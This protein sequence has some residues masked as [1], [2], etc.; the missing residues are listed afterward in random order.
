MRRLAKWLGIVV[1]IVVLLVGGAALI[2]PMVI[3]ID[4]VK[5]EI[6]A[7]VKSATGRDLTIDGPLSLSILPSPSISASKVSLANVP[8]AAA[9]PLASLGKLELK[10][11]L[12][13]LLSKTIVIDR[14]VLVD[15]VINLEVDKQGNGNWNFS[16]AGG[17]GAAPQQQPASSGASGGGS[18]TGALGLLRL[19]DVR[20]ENGTVNY[21]D[22]RSGVH[23][24]VDKID[25]TVSLPS[26]DAPLKADGSLRYNN[27]AVL[28]TLAA[29]RSSGLLAAEGTPA[30]ATIKSDLVNFGFKGTA[31][32]VGTSNG[33]IDLK[34][35]SLR[36][37]AAWAGS[38]IP[39]QTQTFG[40]FEIVG[41]L[42]LAAS[43]IKFSDAQLTFD[44][45][46]GK[47]EI[48]VSTAGARPK[49]KGTLDLASLDLNPYFPPTGGGAAG[50]TGGGGGGS[51]GG[52]S[53][54]SD[55]QF[56]VSG[57]KL[58]DADF[59]LTASAVKFHK[60]TVDRSAITARL[61]AGHLTVD[62][63]DLAAYRGSGKAT[64][65]LDAS[66]AVPAITLNANLSGVQM[67]PLL[68]DVISLDKLSG[69]GTISA[70]LSSKGPSQ[71]ALITALNGKGSMNVANGQISGMDLLKLLNSATSAVGNALT[72]G[73]DTK[74]SHLTGTFTITN[75]IMH[76]N[77]LVLD[78]P[79]LKAEG[80]GTIDLPQR[81][82]DYKV[83]PKVV[84]FGV[85]I[86]VQGPFDNLSY[87]PDVAG[88]VKG[89]ATG[90]VD[91]LKSL[92]PG[93][94]SSGG[95]SSGSG[96]S[97]GGGFPLPNPFK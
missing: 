38:P 3:P 73:G 80:A 29:D 21:S 95:G 65:V 83:T 58:A 25:M 79:G 43:D 30:T 66:A 10:V 44:A 74:F 12:L 81:R 22:Q 91:T 8:G 70:S 40:T 71:R 76:N 14:F 19:S 37:L 16:P 5:G 24:T 20:L 68:S 18:A 54:W 45:I 88:I 56:D 53:G 48:E 15:P 51:S 61:D 7:Q 63:T 42:A 32:L 62:L 23:K 82:V 94:G 4:T 86:I 26:L 90:A 57:F 64:I 35:P 46:K 17:A 1:G 39:G 52:S 49:I 85:P 60:I 92:V 89:G 87:I 96:K 50:S 41:K 77:D 93:Q 78:S 97:G 11:E 69:T 34:V 27:A 75:G 2:L 47:G 9:R 33:S 55:A 72:G 36:K 84:A 67:E 28:L 59:K 31:S 6:I 13:P